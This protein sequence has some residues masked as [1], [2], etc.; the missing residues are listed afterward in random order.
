MKIGFTSQ[1]PERVSGT[2]GDPWAMLEKQ[3]QFEM[4][5]HRIDMVT[6]NESG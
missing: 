5:S 4:L 1:T 6:D 2:L 3:K